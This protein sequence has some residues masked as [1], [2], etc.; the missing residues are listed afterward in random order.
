MGRKRKAHKRP[1]KGGSWDRLK[2]SWLK[3]RQ[4]LGAS[5]PAGRFPRAMQDRSKYKPHQGLQEIDRRRRQQVKWRLPAWDRPSIR[6]AAL[7]PD[8]E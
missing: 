8:R 7:E 3:I 1:Q 2:D 5:K 4:A 6:G